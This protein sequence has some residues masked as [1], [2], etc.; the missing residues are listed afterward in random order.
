MRK[1]LWNVKFQNK[2]QRRGLYNTIN[3]FSIKKIKNM[4][5]SLLKEVIRLIYE[6][7]SF[8]SS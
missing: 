5:Q 1:L 4:D 3:K 8:S 6:R 2:L 7:L